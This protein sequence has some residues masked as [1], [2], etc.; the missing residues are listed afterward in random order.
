MRV[1]ENCY[2]RFIYQVSLLL[3]VSRE[4]PELSAATLSSISGR[5]SEPH[6][7]LRPEVDVG[8]AAADDASVGGIINLDQKSDLHSA[9]WVNSECMR[10]IVT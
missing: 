10:E 4:E 6:A 3:E 5:G 7:Q 1:S 9:P 8:P 2:L